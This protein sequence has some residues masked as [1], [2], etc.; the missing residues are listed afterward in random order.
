MCCIALG[1]VVIMASEVLST[2]TREGYLQC[3]HLQVRKIP[4]KLVAIAPE[5][6]KPDRR[7]KP[8]RGFTVVIPT[9]AHRLPIEEDN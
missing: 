5:K 1:A 8:D 4:S 6:S 7:F 9:S 2:D 3:L